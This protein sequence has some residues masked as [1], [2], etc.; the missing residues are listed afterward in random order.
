MQ[1][2]RRTRLPRGVLPVDKIGARDRAKVEIRRGFFQ[3]CHG[4]ALIADGR[5]AHG[6]ESKLVETG[7]QFGA[8]NEGE[9]LG[10]GKAGVRGGFLHANRTVFEPAGE[11]AGGIGEVVGTDGAGVEFEL[12]AARFRGTQPSLPFDAG[13]TGVTDAAIGQVGELD[14]STCIMNPPTLS[15]GIS[16]AA[17]WVTGAG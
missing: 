5:C 3:Q 13:E 15:V 16:R 8:E 6:P 2:F 12:V 1:S 14:R 9:R 10:P 4:D 7:R 17:A 11:N